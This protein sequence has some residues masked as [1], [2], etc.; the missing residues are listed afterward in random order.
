M[1][2]EQFLARVTPTG[3][4]YLV[5]PSD[6]LAASGNPIYAHRHYGDDDL[7]KIISKARS[8]ESNKKDVYFSLA[9]FKVAQILDRDKGYMKSYRKQENVSHLRSLYVDLDFKEYQ[10]EQDALN[11]LK[12]FLYTTGIT[13]PNIIVHSGGGLHIYWVFDRELDADEWKPMATALAAMGQEQGLKADFGCTIDSARI[14]R[15]PGTL[16]WKYDPP[17]QVRVVHASEKDIDP[18][19][20]QGALEPFMGPASTL[21]NVKT[22]AEVVQLFGAV[23]NRDLVSNYDPGRV[24][25][26]DKI[27][28]RCPVVN[29]VML[30][31]GEGDSYPLWKDVLHLAAYTQDGHSFIHALS[32]NHANYNPDE[33]EERYAESLGVKQRNERGPTTCERFSKHSEKC[34]SCSY[35]GHIKSP[36]SLGVEQKQT[37]SDDI[38]YVIGD[39]TYTN[40]TTDDGEIERRIVCNTALD[41]WQYGEDYEIGSY[42]QFEARAGSMVK[43]VAVEAQMLSDFRQVRS[44]LAKHGVAVYVEQ[45]KLLERVMHSWMEKLRDRANATDGDPAFGW[46]HAKN[47]R[48]V[49][50]F[51]HAGETKVRGG[52]T[53]LAG[54]L[55]ESLQASY[56][57]S[58]NFD[59]WQEVANT[60]LQD[61][62]AEIHTIVATA[63]AAPLMRFSQAGSFTVSA[64]SRESGVGKS[65]A[66]AV[67]QSVWAHP[68]RAGNSLN[69]T[70]ASVVRKMAQLR[71]LPSYWDELRMKAEVD[72]FVKLVFQLSQGKERQ[73]LSSSAKLRKAEEIN[74]FL[75][76]ATN[77]PVMDAMMDYTKLSDAGSLRLFEFRVPRST[78][79]GLDVEFNRKV[80]KLREH[81]GH[82]GDRYSSFLVEHYDWV[83]T[84]I[85]QVAG[86]L[87]KSLTPSSS[88]RYWF[89]GAVSIVAGAMIAR[90]AGIVNLDAKKIAKFVEGKFKEARMKG[91]EAIQHEN[92]LVTDIVGFF[93]NDLLITDKVG[94]SAG[95]GRSKNKLILR[96]PVRHRVRVQIAVDD[97]LIV[98][99]TS[100]LEEFAE[101]SHVNIGTL[102]QVLQDHFNAKKRRNTIGGGT[103]FSVGQGW[104]YEIS[105]DALG[106]DAM[107]RWIETD[108]NDDLR[109]GTT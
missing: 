22:P 25:H 9:S 45:A 48:E 2:P 104:T 98:I 81:Y 77:E 73:R 10:T 85:S 74:T 101:Q 95:K 4:R 29:D 56:I 35:W 11:A 79:T 72:E 31:G 70:P 90:K 28:E 38:S 42:L 37:K 57:P 52:T 18:D 54:M 51:A 69:D 89:Q 24:Y 58:G 26:M 78:R 5:W 102:R 13:K 108:D 16:N 68:V 59:T 109:S 21:S 97:R 17:R 43:K 36:I 60:V 8:L 47:T 50:G 12:S 14:L 19:S 27:V 87:E 92:D 82:A 86:V 84:V 34:L 7:T 83:Q 1:S 23:D 41:K 75:V 39:A 32:K 6:K 64:Y 62:R 3:N 49:L 67:A 100:S 15:V 103:K 40:I 94:S 93:A 33:V 106:A 65:T 20:M 61:D 88:E 30:R 44:H 91:N 105:I 107:S 71:D 63:F 96:E 66:L 53:M 80:T 99:P 46:V 55:D 76:V